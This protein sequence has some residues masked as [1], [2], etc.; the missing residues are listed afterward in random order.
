MAQNANTNRRVCGAARA[1]TD[2]HWLALDCDSALEMLC[3]APTSVY[4]S[5]TATESS[6]DADDH[7]RKRAQQH[8][9]VGAA[10]PPLPPPMY[11]SGNGGCGI[12]WL[13]FQRW[14][15]RVLHTRDG[16]AAHEERCAAR[17]GHLAALT[18]LEKH[19][20]VYDMLRSV[21]FIYRYI[22]RILL[23]I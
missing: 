12:G 16:S 23:T 2:A 22:S 20:F 13:R 5:A 6:G 9:V 10:L 8:S 1:N 14:C 17:G 18:T 7:K 15:L 21:S 4:Y 19:D 11:A 3:E